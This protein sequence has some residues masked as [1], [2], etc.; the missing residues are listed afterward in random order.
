[1][2][3]WFY[4]IG[5]PIVFIALVGSTF[6]LKKTYAS[7]FV[8]ARETERVKDGYRAMTMHQPEAYDLGILRTENAIDEEAYGTIIHSDAFL[9]GL[10][11]MNVRTID[12]SWEGRYED[13]CLRESKPQ[14][15]EAEHIEDQR[16]HWKNRGQ[17]AIKKS[18]SK[19]IKAELDYETRL[20]TITCTDHDPLVATTIAENVEEQLKKYIE[21]YQQGKMEEA[22]AQL[23]A[24]TAQAKAEWEQDRTKEKEAIYTSFA[25]QEVVYKAQMIYSPA[26]AVVAAPSFSYQKVAP[27]RWKMPL[28]LT[29]LLGIGVWCWDNRKKLAKYI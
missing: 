24:A 16:I 4:W 19:A 23:S 14:K 2:K 17:E 22:L 6:L 25:R 29:L 10:L 1:M 20:V 7:S 12:G 13:Y 3:K 28:V 11:D 27:S 9:Q 15:K 26:F 5:L 21:A 18:L 8:V